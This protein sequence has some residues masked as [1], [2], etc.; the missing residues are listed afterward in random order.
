M[1][2]NAKD[3]FKDFRTWIESA[4]KCE[5]WDEYSYYHGRL[6]GMND[7]AYHTGLIPFNTWNSLETLLQKLTYE[8][9][10]NGC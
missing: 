9:I 10:E 5:N 6:E 2:Y 7:I 1:Y 8:T 4:K 3:F